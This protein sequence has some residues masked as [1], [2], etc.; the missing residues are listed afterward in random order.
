MPGT[1]LTRILYPESTVTITADGLTTL[2]TAQLA[3]HQITR[4]S[5]TGLTATFN[6]DSAP[7]EAT[8]IVCNNCQGTGTGTLTLVARGEGVQLQPDTTYHV[9]WDGVKLKAFAQSGNGGVGA[10]A[11]GAT[12]FTLANGAS[13]TI[14]LATTNAAMISFSGNNRTGNVVWPSGPANGSSWIVY[15]GSSFTQTMLANADPGSGVDVGGGAYASIF[16]DNT[17]AMQR[18][19]PDV[20]AGFPAPRRL[21]IT[22][23]SSFTLTADQATY[24]DLAFQG[25][26]SSNWT[27][28]FPGINAAS[29]Y[30]V[31]NTTG[32]TCR[33]N[34]QAN[35][36]PVFLQ[37][38]ERATI[39][40]DG[41]DLWKVGSNIPTEFSATYTAPTQTFTTFDQVDVDHL[42]VG[43]S[44]G[45]LTVLW[46]TGDA[47]KRRGRRTTVFN[48]NTTSPITVKTNGAGA[49]TQRILLPN[50]CASFVIGNDG[51]LRSA[52]TRGSQRRVSLASMT[53]ADY[54]VVSPDF[55][56]AVIEVP[57]TVTLSATRK[58][59]LPVVDNHEWYVKNNAGGAQSITVVGA[60]GTGVTIATARGARVYCDGTNFVRQTADAPFT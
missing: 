37:N 30:F 55:C 17:G 8:W 56:A 22:V 5:N 2:T 28:T 23:T 15:N 43:S 38:S 6:M 46:P 52:E 14:T 26:P 18:M 53:D 4:S 58:V 27:G 20:P 33:L 44:G 49:D 12:A 7:G 3:N 45:A 35:N 50:E 42:D 39:F 9:F 24:Q 32:Q 40:Y 16:I 29:F 11:S 59:I 36:Q 60:T 1:P 31:E 57:N 21:V 48:N 54:T 34:S 19:G 10:R 13:N 51:T 25:S 41:T 47:L